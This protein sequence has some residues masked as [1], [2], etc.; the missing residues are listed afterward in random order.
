ML[1]TQRAQ[2]VKDAEKLAA[3]NNFHSAGVFYMLKRVTMS[4]D[5]TLTAVS[6]QIEQVCQ[7]VNL[8]LSDM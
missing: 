2:R 5:T 6:R 7:Q 1:V 4:S 3:Q 8:N